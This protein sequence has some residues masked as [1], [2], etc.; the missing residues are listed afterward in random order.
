MQFFLS[1]IA[2]RILAAYLCVDSYRVIRDG[3]RDGEVRLLNTD[4]I[5]MILDSLQDPRIMIAHRDTM[6]IRFWLTIGLRSLA[7]AA[8]LVVVVVGWVPKS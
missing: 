7:G 4:W 8:C 1:E 6:P 3:L 2:A 5:G